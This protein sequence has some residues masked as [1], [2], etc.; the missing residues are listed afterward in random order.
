MLLSILSLIVAQVAHCAAANYDNQR[1]VNLGD[2][3]WTVTNNHNASVPGRFPSQA[4]LDL[5][6]AGFIGDPLYGFNDV[7]ELWVQRSNWTYQTRA[8]KGLSRARD[9]QSWLVF[10][11]LDT[12]AN[13]Q[14]CG[15]EVANTQNMYRQYAFDVSKILTDCKGGSPDLSIN[16]G[17]ASKIVLEI[18]ESGPCKLQITDSLTGQYVG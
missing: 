3:S 10:E 6:R 2:L 11:G 7:N 16:F 8:I 13:I 18:A 15:K 12:F 4:H 17:S 9:Q 5:H 1:V 14:L